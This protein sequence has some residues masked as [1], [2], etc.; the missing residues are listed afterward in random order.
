[1][2]AGGDKYDFYLSGELPGNKNYPPKTKSNINK[3]FNDSVLNQINSSNSKIDKSQKST[4]EI[5]NYENNQNIYENGD[6]ETPDI[7]KEENQEIKN[8]INNKNKFEY[9]NASQISEKKSE[10]SSKIDKFN[11]NNNYIKFDINKDKDKDYYLICP[12]CHLYITKIKSVEY[13]NN[14]G[15]F[16]FDYN[17]FCKEK[18]EEYYLYVLIQDKKPICKKHNHE[19]YFIC[20]YCSEQICE[21][22][23]INNHDGHQIRNIINYEVISYSIMNKI[24]DKKSDFKGF[25]IF[26][27]IF[28][29]YKSTTIFIKNV[30][31]SFNILK[32][33]QS[34]KE[35][36]NNKIE[37]NEEN[38]DNIQKSF[39]MDLD[40]DLEKKSNDKKSGEFFGEDNSIKSE[41]K[42]KDQIKEEK[43]NY[44]KPENEI[45]NEIEPEKISVN[46]G[47]Q[48]KK[49]NL[50]KNKIFIENDNESNIKN[51]INDK[52]N[53]EISNHANNDKIKNFYNRKISKDINVIFKSKNIEKDKAKF[54]SNIIRKKDS[55]INI[56]VNDKNIKKDKYN[57][58]LIVNNNNF[59]IP[60]NIKQKSSNKFINT[61]TL[62]GH[63]DRIYSLIKLS[64]GYI[65][66]GSC[67]E[68]IKIW[69]ITQDPNNALISTKNANGIIF[70]LLELKNN[71]LLA[72]NDKNSIDV[73]DLSKNSVNPECSLLGHFFKV[74]AL[75]K[76]NE[77]YFA[78]ASN[79]AKIFIWDSKNKTKI[80]ELLGH[81]GP[82]LTMILLENGNLCSG[83]ENN[84]IRIWDWEYGQCL[85]FFKAH[86]NLVLSLYQFN[87]QIL[88]SGSGDK[89]IKI[90]DIN[91]DMDEIG[92]LN[93][94]DNSVRTLCKINDN[95]FASGSFDNT[96]KI[97]DINGKKCV[98]TL[99]GHSSNV[100]GI[101][102]YDG[103]IIS[104]SN[105]RTIKI[106]EEI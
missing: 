37:G 77:E 27:K 96:I 45:S 86:N 24:L 20:E 13:D 106:W 16:I 67:D 11:F 4:N 103:K 59:K 57:N 3:I 100:V 92:E 63:K 76:C 34:E 53:S 5:S 51:D 2:G 38:G 21:G 41:N 104:C 105:D 88:L 80:K 33:N 73:F 74:T 81:T 19:I 69:D 93:G 94:H 10:K 43:E 26:E 99:I 64:S 23:P 8:S 9:K 65:A 50:L 101:I 72:G 6:Q 36:D 89:K 25:N 91:N 14:F 68:T 62:R 12:D 90:W 1:M 29:F 55:K 97:W 18:K 56:N 22:C 78:S 102:N 17:C 54:D 49:K 83:D 48:K 60:G 58:N 15:E 7:Y 95:Y 32:D 46:D 61:K 39:L 31:S 30:K 98:N 87:S 75:V 79:D 42:N 85:S 35:E 84:T 40:K 28:N 47:S 70:C 44:K 71:E 82:I 52:N 66:T